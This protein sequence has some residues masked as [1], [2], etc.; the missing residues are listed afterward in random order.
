MTPSVTLS[1]SDTLAPSVTT[2]IGLG[3]NLGDPQQAL[4]DALAALG[5]LPQTRLAAISS[6]YLSAPI[7][8]GGNDYVNAVAC[9]QTTLGPHALLD[10]LQAVEATLRE[11][12]NQPTDQQ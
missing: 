7:D 3:A 8:A 5:G 12:L 11:Q 9:L 2:Y 1:P 10:S 6:F 4:R